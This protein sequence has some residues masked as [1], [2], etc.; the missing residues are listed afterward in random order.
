MYAVVRYGNLIEALS[1]EFKD[2]PSNAFEID[3]VRQ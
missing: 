2:L 1:F 3:S